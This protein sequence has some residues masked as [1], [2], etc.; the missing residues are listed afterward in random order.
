M[1][2]SGGVAQHMCILNRIFNRHIFYI[3]QNPEGKSQGIVTRAEAFK[4]KFTAN[5]NFQQHFFSGKKELYAA[6]QNFYGRKDEG[7]FL[8]VI[9]DKFFMPHANENFKRLFPECQIYLL[10]KFQQYNK[11]LWH[12][13]K[14]ANGVLL[15]YSGEDAEKIYYTG[16]LSRK[17]N[18]EREKELKKKYK[19]DGRKKSILI[20]VGGGGFEISEEII[21]KAIKKYENHK[22][23]I[24]Y[25]KFYNGEKVENV[26][27]I[28][29]EELKDIFPLFKKII[30][31]GGYN[32]LSEIAQAETDTLVIPRN[33]EEKI[34]LKYF[35]EKYKFIKEW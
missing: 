23:Y 3:S 10:Q 20:S 21:K 12:R 34:D 29:E 9:W 4:E 14:G 7:E 33:E 13:E 11:K 28:Q 30:C 19:I 6:I 1:G 18:P 31:K 8:V 27:E 32:T 24:A 5:S 35:V 22:I 17:R 15:P 25:G 16:E 26:I 2:N